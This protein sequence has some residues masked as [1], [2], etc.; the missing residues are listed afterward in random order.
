MPTSS[1]LKF[2]MEACANGV[3][4]LCIRVCLC[5]FVTF[6]PSLPSLLPLDPAS[7]SGLGLSQLTYFNI[8]R[9]GLPG[10]RTNRPVWQ[11]R[12]CQAAEPALD[13]KCYSKFMQPALSFM[14][15]L[16]WGGASFTSTNH[17]ER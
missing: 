12:G 16:W 14:L 3:I 15:Y 9:G 10:R 7:V 1:A 8:R 5:L 6:C 17:W 4:S 2:G 13:L 11:M